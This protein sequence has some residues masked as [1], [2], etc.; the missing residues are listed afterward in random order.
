MT[1]PKLTKAQKRAIRE[2]RKSGSPFLSF[3]V[4]FMV[5]EALRKKGLADFDRV[6]G[7]FL[8]P[9]G[10]AVEVGDE[11]RSDGRANGRD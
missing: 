4:S 5:K 9:A 6:T 11:D 1:E 7:W 10:W 2:A 8:T 3:H